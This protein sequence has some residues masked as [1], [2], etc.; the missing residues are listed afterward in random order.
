M[1]EDPKPLGEAPP[2]PPGDRTDGTVGSLGT[3]DGL[4]KVWDG[5]RSGGPVFCPRDSWP[6]AL[7][8]DAAAATYRFVCV[9]C[10]SASPWF[11]SGA[12]GV[13]MRSPCPTLQPGSPLG[14]D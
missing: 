10:G 9:R 13:R 6:L 3:T 1:P 5:F 2:S 12:S 7:A 14:D 4:G 11:E 8:V